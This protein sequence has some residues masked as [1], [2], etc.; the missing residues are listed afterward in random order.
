LSINILDSNSGQDIRN[1]E[2]T[3]TRVPQEDSHHRLVDPKYVALST[4]PRG[5]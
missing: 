2:N 5:R 1:A 4:A 3:C